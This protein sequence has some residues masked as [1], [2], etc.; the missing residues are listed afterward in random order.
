MIFRRDVSEK[1]HQVQLVYLGFYGIY[2]SVHVCDA[3]TVQTF[4]MKE[5]HR[6]AGWV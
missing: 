5:R 3:G 6:I 1:P 2:P 4:C